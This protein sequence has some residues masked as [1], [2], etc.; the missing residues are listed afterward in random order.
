MPKVIDC[1][2]RTSAW[3]QAKKL[4]GGFRSAVEMKWVFDALGIE[5]DCGAVFAFAAPPASASAPAP[6][7]SAGNGY[8]AASLPSEQK[9]VLF[10]DATHGNDGNAG[11]ITAPL[12]TVGAAVKLAVAMTTIY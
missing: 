12:A 11:T 2:V 1:A 7:A 5:E 8:T 4:Q 6:A 10:V 3:T 9:V